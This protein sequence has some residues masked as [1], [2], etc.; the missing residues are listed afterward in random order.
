[1]HNAVPVRAIEPIQDLRGE[2]QSVILRQGAFV[3]PVGQ[4]LAL[5]VFHH[6]EVD[7]VLAADIVEAAD[8]GMTQAG[9][10]SRF[11]L[12]PL[13]DFRASREMCRENFDCDGAVKT[14][15]LSPVDFA[16]AA[17]AERRDDFVGA[18]TRSCWEGHVFLIILH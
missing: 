18:K 12:K 14:S 8:V 4:R 7:I 15:V 9:Y 3:Q 17:R 1:M 13:S 2:A 16:H 11:A 10:S 5:Q 6:K